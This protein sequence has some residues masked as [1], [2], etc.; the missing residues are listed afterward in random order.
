MSDA[1]VERLVEL[2]QSMDKHTAFV[3]ERMAHSGLPPNALV[4][5]SIAKYW[6]ALARLAAE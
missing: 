6:D 1:Q 4:A 2:F 5:E 3:E